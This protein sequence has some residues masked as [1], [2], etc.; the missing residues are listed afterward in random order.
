MATTAAPACASPFER[1]SSAPA[2]AR[3]R[4][5]EIFRKVGLARRDGRCEGIH[6]GKRRQGASAVP[7][8]RILLL[9]RI[10]ADVF[11]RTTSPSAISKR[12][13]HSRQGHGWP[14]FERAIRTGAATG[15]GRT[16]PPSGGRDG[17]QH[18]GSTA[19]QREADRRGAR[20]GYAPARDRPSFTGTLKSQG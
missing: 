15:W 18:H 4:L 13:N 10:E 11:D 9:D 20:R 7:H 8:R 3:R 19:R 1:V 5:P 2:A 17:N 16:L 6:H 14:A 12:S